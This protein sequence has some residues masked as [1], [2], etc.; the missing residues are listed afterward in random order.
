MRRVSVQP[1]EEAMRWCLV[2]FTDDFFVDSAGSVVAITLDLWEPRPLWPRRGLLLG[3]LLASVPM[4]DPLRD[5]ARLAPRRTTNRTAD[6]RAV[7][8]NGE[9]RHFGLSDLS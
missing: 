9:S 6:P 3:L 7:A 1:T 2:C 8:R 4:T 5:V